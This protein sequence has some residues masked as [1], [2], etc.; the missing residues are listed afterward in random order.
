MWLQGVLSSEGVPKQSVRLLC[1][2][3]VGWGGGRAMCLERCRRLDRRV[4]GGAGLQLGEVSPCA[5][6]VVGR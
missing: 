1:R 4:W 6:E 2:R 3:G 5:S